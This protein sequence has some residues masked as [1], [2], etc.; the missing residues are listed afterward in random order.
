MW[1][2]IYSELYKKMVWKYTNKWYVYK[3]EPVSEQEKHQIFR[4]TEIR[5][6]YIIQT[7]KQLIVLFKTRK[8]SK[9]TE[10]T[11]KGKE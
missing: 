3:L 6:H 7:R 2:M 10:H 8:K 1:N 4:D 11:E 5:K 9:Q